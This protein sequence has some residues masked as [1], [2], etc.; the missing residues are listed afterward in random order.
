MAQPGTYPTLTI[1]AILQLD[2][3]Q[4]CLSYPL[5]QTTSDTVSLS[6][7][8]SD[9]LR[10]LRTGNHSRSVLTGTAPFST[11]A[12]GVRLAR[13]EIRPRLCREVLFCPAVDATLLHL[14]LKYPQ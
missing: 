10:N 6:D 4:L 12:C 11:N 5:L 3:Q 1:T 7:G 8:T 13:L 14:A 9:R 2:S